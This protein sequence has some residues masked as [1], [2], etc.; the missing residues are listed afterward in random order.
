MLVR[1]IR[2]AV[3]AG[4][5]HMGQNKY[6]VVLQNNLYYVLLQTYMLPHTY[7]ATHTH[8]EKDKKIIITKLS[9]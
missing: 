8:K 5:G 9:Y 6:P 3:S 1:G 4:R 2:P 7:A